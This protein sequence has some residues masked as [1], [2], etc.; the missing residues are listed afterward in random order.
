MENI[1][2]QTFLCNEREKWEIK[3]MAA[4]KNVWE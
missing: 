4:D 2:S 1:A 3:N